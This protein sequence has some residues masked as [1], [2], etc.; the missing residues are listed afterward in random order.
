M[1]LI[2]KIG[3]FAAGIAVA[4]AVYAADIKISALTSGGTIQITDAIPVARSAT[5]RRV[6]VG[7][8]AANTTYTDDTTLIANGTTYENKA[9][10]NCVDSGGNHLNYTAS[11]NSFSCGTTGTGVA[12]TTGTFT[13]NWVTACTTSDTQSWS[14]TKTGNVVTIFA[15]QNV[16]CTSDTGGFASVAGDMPATIRPTTA[17]TIFGA[18]TVNTG[19]IDATPGCLSI[20]AD[21]SM[22]VLRSV[23]SACNGT[24]FTATGTKGLVQTGMR[25]F[26]YTL[27]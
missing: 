1:T 23:T 12:Q 15:T 19:A 9:V 7:A 4:A 25:T 11:S 2:R 22:Q 3:L 20:N 5:T 18:N 10:P 24:A 17:H 21:G 16:D 6:V 26:T 14:Y 13:L 27:D 8:L